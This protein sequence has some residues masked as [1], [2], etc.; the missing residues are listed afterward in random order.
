M[1][2]GDLVGTS[3]DVQSLGVKEF[4][5]SGSLIPIDWC[6]PFQ[7]HRTAGGKR[8]STPFFLLLKTSVTS[9]N[10]LESF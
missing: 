9:A 5:G 8:R 4:L 6:G 3:V 10:Q 2:E 7:G 1:G